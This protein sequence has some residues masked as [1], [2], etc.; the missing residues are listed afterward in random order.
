[1]APRRADDHL[2]PLK[3]Q[4]ALGCKL[5]ACL[6]AGEILIDITQN[7]WRLGPPIGSGGFGDIYLGK[8]EIRFQSCNF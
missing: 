2:L 1:M 4:A 8:I 5:P 6:P 7:S 3:R